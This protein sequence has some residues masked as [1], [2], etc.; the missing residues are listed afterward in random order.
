MGME[1]TRFKSAAMVLVVGSIGVQ[2]CKRGGGRGGI[3]TRRWPMENKAER[4]TA[5]QI[6]QG[7]H[8]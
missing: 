7:E 4:K 3:R 6:L 1:T 5:S 2:G 8:E